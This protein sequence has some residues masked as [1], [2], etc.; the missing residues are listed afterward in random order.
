MSKTKRSTGE[1]SCTRDAISDSEL[2]SD[3]SMWPNED[4]GEEE[5]FSDVSQSVP[6]VKKNVPARVDYEESLTV[7]VLLRSMKKQRGHQQTTRPAADIG[8]DSLDD[9][10]SKLVEGRHQSAL[11]RIDEIVDAVLRRASEDAFLPPELR[12]VLPSLNMY[13]YNAEFCVNG[14][15]RSDVRSVRLVLDE[16]DAL[17]HKKLALLCT[18]PSSD[19]AEAEYARYRDSFV[20]GRDKT[21]D[22]V[23][24]R[25]AEAFKGAS[26]VPC[27]GDHLVGIIA[28][29]LKK[30]CAFVV[31]SER[32]MALYLMLHSLARWHDTQALLGKPDRD[33]LAILTMLLHR[34]PMSA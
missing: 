1:P 12:S 13:S 7:A 16:R 31:S 15:D 30:E 9:E 27:L 26:A 18:L 34:Y 19:D 24:V 29:C 17:R 5:A 20:E 3:D 22:V 6:I 21:V 14:D 28:P 8:M 4:V 32:V 2:L 23:R 33:Y 10:L 11:D 25:R